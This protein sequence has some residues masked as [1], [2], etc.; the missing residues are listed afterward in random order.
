MLAVAWPEAGAAAVRG[1]EGERSDAENRCWTKPSAS[2]S[3]AS[4]SAVWPFFVPLLPR[5]PRL[6][7]AHLVPAKQP[8]ARFA[9]PLICHDGV[10]MECGRF[11]GP[12]VMLTKTYFPPLVRAAGV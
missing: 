7:A 8:P 4:L 6:A 2:L 10:C 12:V 5:L 11:G 9:A 1:E 3:H